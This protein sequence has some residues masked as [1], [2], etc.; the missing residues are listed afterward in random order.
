MGILSLQG[1]LQF[2]VLL[3][4]LGSMAAF[5]VSI[6]EWSAE[7]GSGG[8][9]RKS[10][11]EETRARSLPTL[12]AILKGDYTKPDES[13]VFLEISEKDLVPESYLQV[14]EN[15]PPLRVVSVDNQKDPHLVEWSLPGGNRFLTQ[16][17][18]GKLSWIAG[19]VSPDAQLESEIDKLSEVLYPLLHNRTHR[20]DSGNPIDLASSIAKTQVEASLTALTNPA[21]HQ[22]YLEHANWMALSRLAQQKPLDSATLTRINHILAYYSLPLEKSSLAG[23]IRGT[24]PETAFLFKDGLHYPHGSQVPLRL[25][26]LLFKANSVNFGT[27]LE[28]IAELYRE[29]LLLKPFIEANGR[30]DHVLL[31]FMVLKAGLPP[32]P[33]SLNTR[34]VIYKTAREVYLQILRAYASQAR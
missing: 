1:A 10:C 28:V 19:P 11:S 32:V 26:T 7:Y 21:F 29:F 13:T 8:S 20:V 6:R 15:L 14:V 9:Y 34:T 25:E 3:N 12:D 33:Q 30:T 5:S 24:H 27:P 2:A 16:F 4:T 17:K 23:V 18:T 22:N 31:D